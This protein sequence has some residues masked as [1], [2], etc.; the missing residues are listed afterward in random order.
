MKMKFNTFGMLALLLALP[1]GVRAQSY[2]QITYNGTATAS[3]G[4]NLVTSA[5]TDQDLVTLS[6][7]NSDGNPFTDNLALVLH[8][9]AN[10]VGDS[11]E[12]IDKDDPN[13][14]RSE[15]FKLGHSFDGSPDTTYTNKDGTIL[16]RFSYIYDGDGGTFTNKNDGHNR[17]SAVYVV[18]VNT[19]NGVT[20]I[21]GKLQFW[22]GGVSDPNP[23]V[24]S[25]TFNAVGPL[26]LP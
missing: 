1:F 21:T 7:N 18:T 24:C 20:N 8:F 2:W 5:M 3:T 23:T 6:A 12:V 19:N 13:L 9:D 17:G 26:P 10:V 11:I 14:F 4:S 25:G 22:L 16:R 15:V